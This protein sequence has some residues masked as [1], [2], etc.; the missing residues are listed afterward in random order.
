[1]PYDPTLIEQNNASR[2]GMRALFEKLS[3]A[4]YAIPLDNDWTIGTTLAHVAV[5]DSRAIQ[6]LNRWEREG[7]APSPNDVDVI[8]AA[9]IPILRAL[10]PASIKTLVLELAETLD[11]KLAAL[12]DNV[13]EQF[14]TVGGK[15]FNL[16]RAK[17]RN[18]HIE[19]IL[20]ALN[21]P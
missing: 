19:Q 15:P 11:A 4:H 12:P 5:F 14:E 2:A 8:N 1:M 20:T 9:L 10:P 13:L 21:N 3:D 18:E 17:H 7:V 6:I 16:S